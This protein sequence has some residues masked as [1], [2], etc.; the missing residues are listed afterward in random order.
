MWPHAQW[1]HSF[2]PTTP[3]PCP[4]PLHPQLLL[5]LS[6][7]PATREA[8]MEMILEKVTNKLEYAC[9]CVFACLSTA[10]CA[11]IFHLNCDRRVAAFGLILTLAV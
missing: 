6:V 10:F 1:S 8:F 11:G 3:H 7:D 2:P 9:V 4:I 5:A